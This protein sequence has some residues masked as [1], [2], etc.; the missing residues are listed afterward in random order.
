MLDH[1]I[2]VK[3]LEIVGNA[4]V[5]EGQAL[6]RHAIDGFLPRLVLFPNTPEEVGKILVLALDEGLT[7]FPWGGGTQMGL[8]APPRQ[9][10]LVVCLGRLD[11]ILDQDPENMTVTAE[12][13]VR[14]SALEE[15]LRRMAPSFFFPLDPPCMEEVTLGGAVAA[16]VSGPSRLRYGTLRDMVLGVGVEIPGVKGTGRKAHAGGKTVKNVSGYDMSK[17]YI[18]SLG[19]LA[20]IEEVTFRILPLPEDRATVL[21]GF[22]ETHSPWA[23]VQAVLESQLIPSCIEVLN[24]QSALLLFPYLKSQTGARAWS[25]VRIEG[26]KEA[27]E[28]QVVEIQRM[29]RSEGAERISVLRGPREVEFWRALGRLG[30]KVCKGNAQSIGLKLSVPVSASHEISTIIEDR[31]QKGSLTCYQLSHAGSGIVYAHM[32][33]DEGLYSEKEQTLIQVV[34]ALREKAEDTDGSLVVEYAPL[35]FKKKVDVWGEV[36]GVVPIMRRLKEE[37]DPRNILNPDRYVGGI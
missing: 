8:G 12:A 27:V 30:P 3:L 29:A 5:R 35:V 13:G 15:S 31:A 14:L 1:R 36:K 25:A 9:V 21:A 17:L 32:P 20:I 7:I 22:R 24:P 2:R 37:F 19:T 28:H 26:I 18:G 10:D 16:N 34:E 4:G 6:R 33:L 11:R 23:C